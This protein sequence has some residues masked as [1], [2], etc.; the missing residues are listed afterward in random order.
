MQQN[1]HNTTDVQETETYPVI[2]DP[3]L[4]HLYNEGFISAGE[5]T[6]WDSQTQAGTQTQDTANGQ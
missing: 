1:M 4:Q 5:A 3:E 2:N 6:F